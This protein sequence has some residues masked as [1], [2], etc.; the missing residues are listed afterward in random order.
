MS[1]KSPAGSPKNTA[2][3]YFFGK[4]KNVKNSKRGKV[5]V[6]VIAADI[7]EMK[8][9]ITFVVNP[10][11]IGRPIKT[12]SAPRAIAFMTSEPLLIPPS[13]KTFEMEIKLEWMTIYS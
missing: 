13:M 10:K 12:I 3:I 11:M 6:D 2:G 4:K 5:E 8:C 7:D 9:L 1:K